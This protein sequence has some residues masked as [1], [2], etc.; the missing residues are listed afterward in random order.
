MNWGNVHR[1]AIDLARADGKAVADAG[2]ERLRAAIG[3]AYYAAFCTARDAVEAA[4]GRPLDKACIHETVRTK[5]KDEHAKLGL[6]LPVARDLGRL[7]RELQRLRNRADY[8]H[9]AIISGDVTCA[10]DLASQIIAALPRA[11]D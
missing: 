11:A 3:R 7:L 9:G 1:L 4:S 6:T 10:L 2:E 8:E 5:L